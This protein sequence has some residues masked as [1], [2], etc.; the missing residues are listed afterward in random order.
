M[1]EAIKNLFGG[2]V[3]SFEELSLRAEEAG[4]RIGDLAE[5]ESAHRQAMEGICIAHAMERNLEKSGAKNG[6]LVKRAID[7]G[8]VSVENGKVV[9]L[10]EQFAALQLSDPYLFRERETARTGGEHGSASMD[11]DGLSDADFYKMRMRN[12]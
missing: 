8:A 7:M 4:V 6:E 12:G 1:N 10:D 2:G 9:G 3:L 11:P 5:A